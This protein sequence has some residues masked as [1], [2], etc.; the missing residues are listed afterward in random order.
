MT[1]RV[2]ADVGASKVSYE[3]NFAMSKWLS[4]FSSY[5]HVFYYFALRNG[6]HC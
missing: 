2:Y 3:K 6:R 5:L 1:A 4:N